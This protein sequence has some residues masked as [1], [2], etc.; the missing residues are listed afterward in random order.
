M[1]RALVAE[2]P[3]DADLYRLLALVQPRDPEAAAQALRRA[4]D[5]AEPSPPTEWLSS[6]G[7]QRLQA[8]QAAEAA[9]AFDRAVE[10]E[11]SARDLLWRGVAYDQRGKAAKA[12]ADWTAAHALDADDCLRQLGLPAFRDYRSR[13][14]DALGLPAS[15]VRPAYGGWGRR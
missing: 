12:Q 3:D 6:L 8:G 14:L 4:V 7:V 13:I 10:L 11:A 1:L 2:Q 9:L 5:L 15:A